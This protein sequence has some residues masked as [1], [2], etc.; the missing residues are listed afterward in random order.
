MIFEIAG[1]PMGKQ[2]PKF[3]RVGGFV[4]TYTPKE[5]VNYEQWVKLCYKQAGGEYFGENELCIDIMAFIKTPKSFSKKK[6]EQAK[7]GELRPT[8]KPDIDNILKIICDSLNGVAYKDDKQIVSA[9]ISKHYTTL[10]PKVI[11]TIIKRDKAN[12]I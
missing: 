2:R 6:T 10:E 1:E 5:T 11:V 8:K 3:S 9:S 7:N 12:G 4:K